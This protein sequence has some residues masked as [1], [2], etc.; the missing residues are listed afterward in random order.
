MEA[1]EN[2]LKL[3][4]SQI[5]IDVVNKWLRPL[6]VVNFDAGN[7]FLQAKDTFQINWFKEHIQKKASTLLRNNNNKRIQVHLSTSEEKQSKP[8]K[9]GKTLYKPLPAVKISHEE[10][11]PH[12]TFSNYVVS[13]NNSLLVKLFSSLFCY[14]IEKSQPIS[15]V[16][17]SLGSMN[18]IYVHGI[19]GTGKTH[20][21]QA[22]TQAL[23]DHGFNA[24]YT[25]ADTFTDHVV[26]AIRSG[27]MSAFRQT[28][29]NADV[30]LIDD[31][32][33]FSRK[34]A[35][36]EE[37]FHT[38][39]TLHL[40]GRQIIL[41]SHC[42]PAE[43][44]SIEPRLVSRFE[45]GIVLP[46]AIYSEKELKAIL[47]NKAKSFNFPLHEKVASY[48]IETFKSSS[49]ALIRSLEALMLRM[50]GNQGILSVPAAKALLQDLI[51]EEESKSL[52]PLKIVQI[53][54]DY[55]GVETEDI[56]GKA[57]SRDCVLPR[58]L[59]M[60]FCRT[61]LKMPFMKI[62]DFFGKDHSTVMSS[63][64][65]IQKAIDGDDHEIAAKWD[66]LIKKIKQ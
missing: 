55:F 8:S 3:Q 4:D 42:S 63:V 10:L 27:E 64:K 37:L 43:L 53:I 28:Y 49:K 40:S 23:R 11:D 44:Q 50:T 45:W 2:F 5:G 17:P 21:L 1:W 34:A 7:L 24:L 16:A 48:L 30:L 60:H 9:K 62:G 65:L 14:D 31:V 52:T 29:R 46:L 25:R 20:L 26:Y 6:K 35:T 61:Q 13:E 18:P 19:S 59:A 32:H 39:N 12:N 22:A 15:G 57:Q 54:S 41:S 38:F 58:Q 51:L 33:I 47:Q 66:A 36:Q 56:L